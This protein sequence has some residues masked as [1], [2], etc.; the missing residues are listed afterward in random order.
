MKAERCRVSVET[1]CRVPELFC[2]AIP[3]QEKSWFGG[4]LKSHDWKKQTEFSE[5]KGV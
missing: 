2:S 4:I 5:G 1:R 3:Q